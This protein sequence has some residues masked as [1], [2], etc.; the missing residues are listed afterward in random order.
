MSEI[1]EYGRLG[2]PGIGGEYLRLMPHPRWPDKVA[3]ER[4]KRVNSSR[5]EPRQLN[6]W[7]LPVET[8]LFDL[9]D[10]IERLI[11]QHEINLDRVGQLNVG[12]TPT[13]RAR[14]AALAGRRS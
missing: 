7:E 6:I 10:I 2:R 12:D 14:L 1:M 9:L 13:F 3:I 5:D 4:L 8:M 11:E